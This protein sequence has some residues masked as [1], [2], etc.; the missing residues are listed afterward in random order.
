MQFLKLELLDHNGKLLSDNFYWHFI[1]GI[2]DI[3]EFVT[4]GKPAGMAV[5][6]SPQP[7]PG[8][9][10]P[11]TIRLGT[12]NNYC[13]TPA[14]GPTF[15]CT[16]GWDW[17]PTIPDRNTGIWRKVFLSA[18]GPAVI[19]DPLITT[20]L[21]LPRTDSA[22]ISIQAE[23]RNVTAQPLK[24]ELTAS[25]DDV[26]VRK[27]VEVDAGGSKVVGFDPKQF[28]SLRVLNPKL[29]WPN[30]FGE[31]NLHVLH[32][33]LKSGETISD[34]QDVTFGI[35][36][37][38]YTNPPS[39]NM[40]FTV[41]GVPIFV[42]GGNWGLD[43]A[44][45]RIPRERLEAQVKMHR[46]ANLNM[47]RNW[48]GQSTNEDLYDLCDRYGLLMWDEFF[49]PSGGAPMPTDFT[50]YMANVRDKMLRFRNHPSIAIWCGRNEGNPP[51]DVNDA[52][53]ELMKELEPT[54][55]YQPNSKDGRG[56]HS[57]G[58]YGW[59]VPQAYYEYGDEVFKTEIGSVSIPTFESIQGMLPE[60][61]WES[62][63]DAWATHDLTRG[64][65]SRRPYLKSLNGRYGPAVNLA[66]FTRKGQLMNYE[67]FRAMYEG[68]QAKLFNPAT[69]VVTWM[70]NPAQPSFVWQLYHYDLEPNS[71]LFAVRKACEPVHIQL[72]ESD[73]VLQV[74]NNRPS[75]LKDAKARIVIYNLDGSSPYQ[76]DIAVTAA[77]SAATALGPVQWPANLSAV[78]FIKL[79]LRD[80]AGKLLSDNFY[81]RTNDPKLEDLSAL[82]KL[83]PVT[84]EAKTSRH[85]KDGKI[86]LQV[87]L[88]NPA[89]TVALMVHAQ[90]RR[91]G[92]KKRILPVFYSDNYLSLAPKEEKTI[93]IEAGRNLLNGD[94]P[95]VAIDGWNIEGVQIDAAAETKVEINRN[96]RVHNWPQKG[97]R[98]NY[99]TPQSEYRMN[100]GG[101]DTGAFKND[102]TYGRGPTGQIKDKIDTS[103]PLSAPEAVYQTCRYRKA[104]YIFPMKPLAPGK[105][106]TVRLH[107]AELVYDSSGQRKIDVNI[108][109][110]AL[111]KD[112]DIVQAVGASRKAIVKEITG[113]EP[114]DEGNIDVDPRPA[115][116]SKVPPA[117]S[118]IEIFLP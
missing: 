80:A 74:I 47:I 62:I 37:I 34:T 110:K 44:L 78:H 94:K 53:M 45:K 107:F 64:A 33:V 97:F 111:L 39:D 1:R 5:R 54:R 71:A 86:L 108:N 30:G 49:Q 102:E 91:S 23:V 4:A 46:L 115:A 81:W 67:A 57:G 104:S 2:F 84:L 9:T 69:G 27:T 116:G 42:K 3:S 101:P 65:Q 82:D 6:I 87:S 12:G 89:P 16:I 7:T 75:P 31:P 21:P 106:Y 15:M 13:V 36:K 48:V 26:S 41:N 92:D 55:L 99:G 10:T 40:A 56:I 98:I 58:P 90:L 25:F 109:G 50:A 70:S 18:S 100:C 73:W 38:G 61:D 103:D 66:D 20:D 85:D 83:S 117:I 79:E 14:D 59:R 28:P 35:R 63:D 32:L 93:T 76:N 88:R 72:N 19:K 11:H 68:R 17:L 29:W 24:A 105:T 118:G 114:D 43:E 95:L 8:E 112:F 51:K 113:I 22:D 52:I 96:A 77:P 60:K